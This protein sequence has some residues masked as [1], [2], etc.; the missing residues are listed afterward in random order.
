MVNRHVTNRL[1]RLF[2]DSLVI[3][4]GAWGTEFQRRGLPP[5]VSADLWNLEHPEVVEDV[6]RSYVEAGSQVIL[7]NTFRANPIALA[8]QGT[9]DHCAEINRRGVR[10]SRSAAGEGTRVFGSIGP[11][12]KRLDAGEIDADNVTAAFRTQAEALAGAGV[13]ALLFETFSDVEEARLAVRGAGNG[14]PDRR[15]VLL[16]SG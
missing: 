5:G 3:T 10:I 15:L 14:L 7:T 16:Q 6:A 8:N 1:S 9:S 11:T 12:G 13:D 4:D 2:P